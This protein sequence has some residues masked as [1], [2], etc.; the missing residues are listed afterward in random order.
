MNDYWLAKLIGCVGEVDSRKRLQKAVYLL[1]CQKGFPLQLDYI[2][3]YYGPYSFGLA[4][5]TEQL[6]DAK[7]VQDTPEVTRF[8]NNR[9]KSSLTDYGKEVVAD[10]EGTEE[11][12]AAKRKIECF[13]KTF[14]GLNK[15][16]PRVLELAATVAYF[17]ENDLDEAAERT[18]SFKKVA[19]RDPVLGRARALAQ[20]MLSAG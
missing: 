6:I 4:E 9:H 2:L 5:L 7:I 17:F 11:G 14:Q 3:H 16:D 20:E 12:K 19:Q 18:A 1:Q 8:G 13:S 15:E 10:F